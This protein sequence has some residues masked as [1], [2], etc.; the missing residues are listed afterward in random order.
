MKIKRVM[1]MIWNYFFEVFIWFLLIWMCELAVLYSCLFPKQGIEA[2]FAS[3]ILTTV[4]RLY[5]KFKKTE[6]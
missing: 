5:K 6:E 4:P 3:I 1:G 2:V